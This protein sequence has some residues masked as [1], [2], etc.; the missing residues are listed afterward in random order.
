MGVRHSS[1]PSFCEGFRARPFDCIGSEQKR[2]QV[3]DR[4]RGV[5]VVDDLCRISL[6]RLRSTE[7]IRT[8]A[9][10]SEDGTR[11]VRLD[12][13]QLQRQALKRLA[14]DPLRI[15]RSAGRPLR[16]ADEPLAVRR[17]VTE[18]ETRDRASQL[19][20]HET[21]ALLSSGDRSRTL[22]C[23]LDG[24]RRR[25]GAL[26]LSRFCPVSPARPADG[27]GR[28][29]FADQPVSFA[30]SARSS[31]QCR[32]ATERR[33]TAGIERKMPGSPASSAPQRIARM[34]A[35]G[36]RWIPWPMIRG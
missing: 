27:R 24:I 29:R 25:P 8:D 33:A 1:F 4:G 16:S 34:T 13:R 32:N 3:D 22:S 11:E 6:T 18:G 31:R 20:A 30:S 17:P 9:E 15:G 5:P 23:Q 19:G 12:L 35:S 10:G 21:N 2:S 26:S 14:L 7:T 28:T 36:C